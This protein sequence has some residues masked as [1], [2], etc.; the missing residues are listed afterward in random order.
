MSL[1]ISFEGGEGSG[2]TTQAEMLH[3]RLQHAGIPSL[4]VREPGTTPLGLYLRDWLK[5]E[6]PKEEALSHGAELFLFAAARA[7][8]VAKVLR[9][10]LRVRNNVVVADRYADSTTAYQ[11]HGRRLHM[12]DVATINRLATGGLMPDLTFL[13]DCSP[14]DG[15]KRVGSVQIRLPL[16]SAETG[17]ARRMDEEGTQR[18]EQED[19]G[20]HER[21]RAGYRAIARQDPERWRVI[22]AMG[23]VDAIGE[24]IWGLVREKL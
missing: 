6:T 1:F 5:K 12:S 18:F 7:E 9:P 21:V 8:F 11:G 10:A 14:L 23:D 19:L 22:D 17:A 15:L 24:A 16:E 3:R 20:F 2:K 4:L 13:L